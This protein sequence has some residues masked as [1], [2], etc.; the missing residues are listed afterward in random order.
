M[1]AIDKLK[2]YEPSNR[3]Q[4]Y[5]KD[6]LLEYGEE[7]DDIS[8]YISDILKNGCQSGIVGSLIY[9][10]DTNEFYDKYEDEIE[11]LL[12]EYQDNCG[13]NNRMEAI[14]NLNGADDVGNIMQEKNLLAWF[15][16][17]TAVSNIADELEIEW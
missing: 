7:Y 6:Y 3:L 15:G 17:E 4:E 9:Y 16:F 2:N 5:V 10:K 1:K 12:E 13:Y 14:A 8:D 11:D